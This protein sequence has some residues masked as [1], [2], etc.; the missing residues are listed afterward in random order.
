MKTETRQADDFPHLHHV[1]VIGQ[2]ADL[3]GA[4]REAVEPHA[5]DLPESAFALR[6]SSQGQYLSVTISL[7]I[8]NEAQLLNIYTAVKAVDGVILCL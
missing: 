2:H 8:Q 3:L 5:P 7:E 4:V 6:T 1:K